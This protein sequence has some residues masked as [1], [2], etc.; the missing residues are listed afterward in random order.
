MHEFNAGQAI[1]DMA[2]EHAAGIGRGRV[3]RTHVVLGAL[4]RLVPEY[5]Q[6][7]FRTLSEGTPV[8]GSELEIRRAQAKG[9]C[10]RCGCTADMPELRFRCAACGSDEGVITGGRELFVDTL[11]IEEADITE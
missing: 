11:E 5:L 3:V 7:A 1:V 4:H 10:E 9:R 2:K 6:F 8:Q